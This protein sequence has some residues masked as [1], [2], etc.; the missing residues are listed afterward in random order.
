MSFLINIRAVDQ[1]LAV[2]FGCRSPNFGVRVYVPDSLQ[3]ISSSTATS[4]HIPYHQ[5][6]PLENQ[7]R[8]R[9]FCTYHHGIY[10][11]S[12]YL[13]FASCSQILVPRTFLVC[14]RQIVTRWIADARSRY[15]ILFIQEHERR[16]EKVLTIEIL[17]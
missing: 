11:F 9:R 13:S 7:A 2:F 12:G 4:L 5:S 15:R 1:T 8:V 3:I 16:W 6:S 17:V 10:T 14:F